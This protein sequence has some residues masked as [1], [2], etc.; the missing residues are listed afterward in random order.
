MLK[1]IDFKW[2]P[3]GIIIFYVPFH[4]L[5]EAIF[6]FPLWM[7]EHYGLPKPLSYP[8]WLINNSIF[9]IVLLTGQ[10]IYNNNRDKN[11]FLAIGILLWAIMNSMEHIIFTLADLKV[12]PGFYTAILFL[13]ISV[14]GFAKLSIDNKLNARIIL[15]SLIAAISYWLV[16]FTIIILFGTLLMKIFP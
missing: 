2:F 6:N 9:L 8:H 13:I 11:L 4:L 14:A 5:E 3:I 15:K 1:R 12:T 16:S 10:I 7:Y